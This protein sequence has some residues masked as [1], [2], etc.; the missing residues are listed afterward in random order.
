MKV[1]LQ[2]KERQHVKTACVSSPVEMETTTSF[3][4][5]TWLKLKL[6]EQLDL[7]ADPVPLHP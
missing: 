7:F 2:S 6:N 3:C 4:K 1:G 5:P